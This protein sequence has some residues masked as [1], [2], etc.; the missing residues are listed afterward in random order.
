MEKAKV[1]LNLDG[2]SGRHCEHA[3]WHAGKGRGQ[4]PIHSWVAWLRV[5]ELDALITEPPLQR[6]TETCNPIPDAETV[7]S[8]G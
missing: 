2:S 6:E 3:P 4:V 7:S 1:C 8:V 5:G